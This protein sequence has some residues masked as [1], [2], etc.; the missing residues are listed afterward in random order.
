MTSQSDPP[1]SRSADTC[2]ETRA[3]YNYSS[4]TGTPNNLT[5]Y[6]CPT[7][8]KQCDFTYLQDECLSMRFN[9]L[10]DNPG[11]MF[12]AAVMSIWAVLFLEMWKRKQFLL[13]HRW[14]MLGYEAAEVGGGV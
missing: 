5:F 8:D 9:H 6:M 13:Q 1:S 10:F 2:K 11:T 4:D 3:M 14:G 7:C 12:F